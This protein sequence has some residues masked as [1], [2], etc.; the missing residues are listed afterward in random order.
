MKSILFRVDSSPDIGIG[1]IIRCL[2]LADSLKR[3][4]VNS[5]FICR[6]HIGSLHRLISDKGYKVHLL[7]GQNTTIIADTNDTPTKYE[8]WLGTSPCNDA[9]ETID[10]IL[11]L[12]EQVDTLCLDHYGINQEWCEL[13][14]PYA[15]RLLAI[16]DLANRFLD[17]DWILNQSPQA[18]P[19]DYHCLTPKQCL[20][21]VGAQFAL[22]NSDI[23]AF[24]TASLARKKRDKVST[25]LIAFGGGDPDNYSEKS[26]L[27]ARNLGYNALIIATEAFPYLS[28]LEQLSRSDNK[29]ELHI[30]ISPT[31]VGKL[32]SDSDIAFGAA[33]GGA[34]ERC[35]LG[36]PTFTLLTAKNQ[37]EQ[38]NALL[39]ANA[40]IPLEQDKLQSNTIKKILKNIHLNQVTKAAAELIDGEGINRVVRA[41]TNE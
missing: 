34:L 32:I 28:Q 38:F 4:G 21:L 26:A 11:K 36:L 14:R 17:C 13:I 5:Q 24:R 37:T 6:S 41:I 7:P 35:C 19:S 23:Y 9:H 10:I 39:N 15:K 22:V 31:Q 33:G 12:P 18:I 3:K 8:T 29:V 20:K 40:I 16:D 1:H 2:S 30:N 25:A 27:I